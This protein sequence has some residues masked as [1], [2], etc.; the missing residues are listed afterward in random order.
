ME[1]LPG[2]HTK[3]F[4]D[5]EKLCDFIHEKVVLHQKTLDIQEPR[6]FIDCFLIKSE[7]EQNSSNTIYTPESLVRFVLEMFF[8]GTVN[9][10]NVLVSSLL[11]VAKLPHIQA[12]VQQEIAEVVGTNRI[13]GMEDRLK[14]PFTNAVIH[15]V[16]R[17][18]KDSLEILPRATTCDIKFHGYNISK[19]TAVVPVLPSVHFD[20]LQW[21]SP[22]K[23]NPDHFLDEK[24]QFRK[25]DAFMAFSAGKRSCPG[26]ALARME[27]FL[28]FS[29]LLQKFT[30]YLDVDTKDMDVISLFT[31]VKNNKY[32]LLRAIKC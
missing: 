17:C 3:T 16:Q 15:E 25:R 2:Q 6:D 27:L 4:A 32:P 12:K 23:F 29:A 22:E 1:Y 20:P 11:V 18:W 24:G 28:F 19:Y 5:I 31:D 13:P 21:E 14:M 30:F 10:S 9:I 26:E 8:A 7:K